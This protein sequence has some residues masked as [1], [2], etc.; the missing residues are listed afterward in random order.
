MKV[1]KIMKISLLCLGFILSTLIINAQELRPFRF[2]LKASPNIGWIKPDTRGLNSDGS[3]LG[4]NYGLMAEF[5]MA[6]SYNYGLGT[7]LE[8]SSYSGK[9]QFPDVVAPLDTALV[10]TTNS[11]R[12]NYRYVDI[13]LTIR[14][15]TNEIG[16]NT[17]FA[18]FGF[19]TGFRV[20]GRQNISYSLASGN[21]N[22]DNIDILSELAP[23]R[24]GLILGGGVEYNFHG[25]T[26]LVAGITF[27]NGFSNIF[28]KNYYEL[29]TNGDVKLTNNKTSNTV[30]QKAVSNF[31]SLDLGIFF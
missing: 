6:N 3:T 12:Y 25:K 1:A 30:E 21:L 26:A 13:P 4:F 16:Y 7:G 11:S 23:F 5:T 9:L 20:K 18:N 28:N 2:G 29:D 17:Y 14:M 15:K 19:S 10:N 31:I 24:I 8:I 27:N 22:E